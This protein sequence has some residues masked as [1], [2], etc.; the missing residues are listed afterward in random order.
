MLTL[1]WPPLPETEDECRA[2]FE[3]ECHMLNDKTG[4]LTPSGF[5]C[6]PNPFEVRGRQLVAASTTLFE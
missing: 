2:I 6:I 3:A 4:S 1:L 5:L